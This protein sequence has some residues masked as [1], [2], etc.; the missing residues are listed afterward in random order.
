M[1]GTDNNGG[2][3]GASQYYLSMPLNSYTEFYVGVKLKYAGTG[4]AGIALI[5]DGLNRLY[6][7][8]INPSGSSARLT[9][10]SFN[11]EASNGWRLLASSPSF[12]YT[13][14]WLT[15]IIRYRNLGGSIHISAEAYSESGEFLASASASSTSPRR[16][17]ATYVGLEID[18]GGAVFDDFVLSTRNPAYLTVTGLPSLAYIQVYDVN[19][20]LVG[21]ASADINGTASLRVIADL[22]TGVGDGA[23]LLITSNNT[24]CSLRTTIPIIGGEEYFV[25]SIQA[26]EGFADPTG[27]AATILFFAN[28]TC[29][30]LG[31]IQLNLVFT[32]EFHV[33]LTLEYLGAT[34]GVTFT[35]RLESSNTSSTPIVV[36]NGEIIS[37]YTS[38]LSL[39]EGGLSIVA[40]ELFYREA[41]R[42]ELF[43][44]YCL[45]NGSVCVSYPLVLN[46]T[47]GE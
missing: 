30:K 36:V 2:I 32:E 45:S 42:A 8:S 19:G 39:R 6:E 34:G 33:R 38:T 43:I 22:V 15:L 41:Y 37:P 5:N 35:I 47:V 12:P 17:P 21:G 40:N 24:N 26:F 1:S 18:E 16:F 28:Y 46:G 13:Q 9:I 10:W 7:V 29:S 14:Q 11:V 23:V 3:G 25:S 20:S 4:Y 27:T 31:I 44:E